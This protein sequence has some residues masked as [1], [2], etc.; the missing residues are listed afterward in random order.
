MYHEKGT[1]CIARASHAGVPC[2]NP[3]DPTWVFHRNIPA[4]C[5]VVHS[6]QC[7][8]L[9]YLPTACLRFER[10][11][12]R[13]PPP[14]PVCHNQRTPPSLPHTPQQTQNIY[15]TFV[16]RRPNGF[17][18]GPTLYKCYTNVS[19][20]LGRWFLC[21]S[22]NWLMNFKPFSLGPSSDVTI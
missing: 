7:V 16:Q 6:S 8:V 19:C 2:S 12:P 13:P 18:V 17:A 4:E 22:T 11:P 14:P 3:A 10:C 15:I 9:F 1:W 21:W 5:D 20:L